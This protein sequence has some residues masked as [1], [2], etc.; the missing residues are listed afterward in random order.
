MLGCKLQ[1]LLLNMFELCRQ[2]ERAQRSVVSPID[3]QPVW[4][5]KF[6]GTYKTPSVVSGYTAAFGHRLYYTSFLIRNISATCKAVAACHACTPAAHQ[7]PAAMHP[8][9]SAA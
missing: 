2:T 1:L 7:L 8:M 6:V 9:L 3:K 5:L 4:H